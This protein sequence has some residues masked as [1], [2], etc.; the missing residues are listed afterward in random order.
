MI[1]LLDYDWEVSTSTTQLIPNLEIMKLAA[2]Y[3]EENKF[4]QLISLDTKDLTQYEKIYFFS[5]QDTDKNIPE[6]FLRANNVVFGGTGF[7]KGIYQPFEESLIDYMIPRTYIYKNCLKQKYNDGIKAKIINNVLDD[8]YYRIYI[9]NKILPLPPMRPHKKL[10]LYDRNI[11]G[12]NWEKV[13]NKIN[14]RQPSSIKCIHP[15]VCENLS[16]YFTIRNFPA[17][18]RENKIIL[19]LPIPLDEVNIMLNKYKNQFLADITF[20]SN[21]YLPIGG[22]FLNKNIYYK[23]FIYT[24]NL[25]FAFWSKGIPIKIYFRPTPIGYFNPLET[26]EK[27]LTTFQLATEKNRQMTLQNKIPKKKKNNPKADEYTQLVTAYPA[28][29]E[30]FKQSFNKLK[31]QG[32]WRL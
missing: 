10:Y 3:Q 2:Y 11:F 24:L 32:V 4:C 21:I 8:A 25:L 6:Q 29:Q 13:L 9:D 18:S 16:T 28:S 7:T 1:G 15:V 23:D 26:L 31:Q 19:D 14:D 12:N 22:S 17:F 20:T 27:T 5:E 30:L